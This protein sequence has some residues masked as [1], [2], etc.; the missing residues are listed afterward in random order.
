MLIMVWLQRFYAESINHKSALTDGQRN[1]DHSASTEEDSAL[2]QAIASVTAFVLAVGI[3]SEAWC[4][5]NAD[6]T[7]PSC[8]G[9]HTP[10]S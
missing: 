3:N 4:I 10:V 7:Q 6:Q 1:N 9:E 8:E 2:V 5:T